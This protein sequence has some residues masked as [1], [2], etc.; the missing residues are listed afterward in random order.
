MLASSSAAATAAASSDPSSLPSSSSPAASSAEG[1]EEGGAAA[2]HHASHQQQHH[3]VPEEEGM[4]DEP[5]LAMEEQGVGEDGKVGGRER[6][7]LM[8]EE[9]RITGA[10]K[11]TVYKYVEKRGREGGR[12]ENARTRARQSGR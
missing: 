6:G 4:E 11:A 1:E 10:V 7:K 9:E 3:Q 12:K 5:L 8:K 2:G